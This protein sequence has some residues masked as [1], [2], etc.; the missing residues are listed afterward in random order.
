MYESLENDGLMINTAPTKATIIAMSWK[1]LMYSFKKIAQKM[2][3]KKGLNLFK[4]SA[5]L[6]TIRSMV[7]KFNSTPK[8]PSSERKNRSEEHTSELQSR[9]DLVCRL[10]LE[11]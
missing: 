3:V 5:S 7:K 6:K 9:F 11:K 8:S 10:L 2:M 4:I 1:R